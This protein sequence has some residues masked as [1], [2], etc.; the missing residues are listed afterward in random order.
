MKG[1]RGKMASQAGHAFLHAFWDS[2]KRFPEY[3]K[4]YLESDH[5]IKITCVV[6]SD[7]ELEQIYRTYRDI[8]GATDVIDS[9]FTVF[10]GPTRTC[11]GIGPIP[12]ELVGELKN[13]KLLK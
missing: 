4:N 9:G 2:E 1:I 7:S 3:A 5:A 6:D 11:I 13:L 12:P 10:N 8:C